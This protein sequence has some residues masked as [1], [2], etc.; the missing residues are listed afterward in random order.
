MQHDTLHTRVWL[1]FILKILKE[2]PHTLLT[3]MFAGAWCLVNLF[4]EWS[5]NLTTQHECDEDSRLK[6]TYWVNRRPLVK[7]HIHSQ[8]IHGHIRTNYL[9]LMFLSAT[10]YLFPLYYQGSELMWSKPNNVCILMYVKK[11]LKKLDFG[12]FTWNQWLL[13]SLGFY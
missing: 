6:F 1:H 7:H 9:I 10:S 12:L 11:K 2:N 13:V 4:G 3:G 8:Q 5:I